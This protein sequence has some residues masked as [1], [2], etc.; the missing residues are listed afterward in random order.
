[1]SKARLSRKRGKYGSCD[2]LPDIY[3]GDER[4]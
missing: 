2:N 3:L 1:M 4:I